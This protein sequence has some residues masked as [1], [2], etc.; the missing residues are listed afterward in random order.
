VGDPGGHFGVISP[1]IRLWRPLSY[2][3]SPFWWLSK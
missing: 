2:K 1:P 3:C